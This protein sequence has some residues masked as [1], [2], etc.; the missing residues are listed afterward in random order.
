MLKTDRRSFVAT[1][2]ACALNIA[3]REYEVTEVTPILF[4]NHVDWIDI[5]YQS[6]L[7]EIVGASE[8]GL[9]ILPN[10]DVALVADFKRVAGV[11]LN[12]F[13]I[14]NIELI[15]SCGLFTLF[16]LEKS[17]WKKYRFWNYPL[18]AQ[19]EYTVTYAR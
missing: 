7:I 2:A 13:N 10:L 4:V 6:K 9:D 17:N 3:F 1:T 11:D 19:P 5:P 8:N 12:I 16:L 15:K 18:S 14:H